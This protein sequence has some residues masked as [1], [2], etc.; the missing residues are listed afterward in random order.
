M[1]NRLKRGLGRGL[2]SLLGDTSKKISANKILIKDIN[3]NRL[4]PRKYFDKSSLEDLTN[5][6]KEQGVIQPIVVRP[7][8]SSEGK[9]EIVAGE[10]RWLASQNAGLHEVPVVILDIDDVKSLEFA[11]VENVQRQD[12]NPIEEAKGY[13][14]LVDD[15]NYNQEKLSQFIGKSRSYIANSLRL[16][17][18]PEEVLLMVQQGNLS[19]GHARTLIGLNNSTE[20]AKKIIQKKL[21]VRQSEVLVRQFRNKKFKLISKKDPNILD[22]QKSLEEKVGLIVS[23]N[24]KKDNSGIISFEYQNLDQLNKLIDTIKKN[25]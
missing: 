10:R 13:Q 12:L 23:I 20:I 14:K 21:S 17:S 4:Q 15:F 18:L 8:K 11:I 19:A 22:L 24:N 3:R 5:S 6:I 1:E 2:S 16:L 25:Y 7:D 9:Y